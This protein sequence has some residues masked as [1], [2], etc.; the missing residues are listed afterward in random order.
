M[1][2]D[3][4]GTSTLATIHRGLVRFPSL[5]LVAA[6]RDGR[7]AACPLGVAPVIVGTHPEVDLPVNDPA[8]SRRHCVVT[9]TSQGILVR[10][11][12]SKNGTSIGGIEIV[13]AYLPTTNFA[14]IGGVTIRAHMT[15]PSTELAVWSDPRFGGVFG[16][17]IVMRALFRLLHDAAQTGSSILLRGEAG[18]GKTMLAQAIHDA[19]PWRD[20]PLVICD[21]TCIAGSLDALFDEA[22]GGTLVLDEISAMP[23]DLQ[24]RL[25]SLL[26]SKSTRIVATTRRDLRAMVEAGEFRSDLI[27]RLASIEAR[28]PSLR[29]RKDDIEVLVEQILAAETPPQDVLALPPGI[30]PMLTGYDW[31]GNVRE[32]KNTVIRLVHMPEAG[33]GT[34]ELLAQY[35]DKG[36]A[37][38][39]KRRGARRPI[40]AS[41]ARRAPAEQRPVRSS[42]HCDQASRAWGQR[43]ACGGGYGH[44]A[45]AGPS[46]YGSPRPPRSCA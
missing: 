16:G 30:M 40:R 20:G 31:P 10:D 44:F 13:E 18:T 4:E 25:L 17:S 28:V 42:L 1:R 5:V 41:L 39:G 22:S 6:H 23:M 3:A 36:G 43:V 32:L 12:R 14:R 38:G 45:P 15:G 33:V 11:L 24:A 19:S 34:F 26:E 35:W 27:Y 2:G 29:N 37:G 46:A 8:V 9:L 21:V 7:E